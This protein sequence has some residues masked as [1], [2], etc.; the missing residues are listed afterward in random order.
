MRAGPQPPAEPQRPSYQPSV[1][2]PQ[3]P[4]YQ[5]SIFKPQEQIR[6]PKQNSHPPPQ[7]NPNAK[8]SF[9]TKTGMWDFVSPQNGKRFESGIAS[10]RGIVMQAGPQ[11]LA[12]PQP[13]VYQPQRP[14]YQPSVY[15]PGYSSTSVYQPSVYQPQEQIRKPKQNSQQPRQPNPNAKDSFQTKT[16]M[17]DFVSPE[18]GKRFE[19]GIASSRGIV[20]Q[21]GPQPPAEPQPSVYQPQR[22]SYQPSV[23]QP[24]RP[25]YQPS[26]YKPQEQIRKLKQISQKR[27]QS[28]A[29]DSFQTK[30][31]MWDFV[32]PQ[33]GKRFESGIAQSRGIVMRAGPQ[34]PAEPQPSVYQPQR[35]SYQPSVYQPQRPSYQPSVYQPVRPSYQPSVYQPQRPSYQPSVYQPQWPSYQPSVYPLRPQQPGYH[36]KS[37]QVVIQTQPAIWQFFSADGGFSD[38]NVETG[39]PSKHQQHLATEA[40]PPVVTQGTRNYLLRGL[41]R[42]EGFWAVL[43]PVT[44]QNSQQPRQPN[45]NA[46]DSFQTKTGMWDFVS[47]ENGRRFES[48][49]A[50][51]RGIVMQ[52]GPQPPAEPQRPSYQPSVYQPQRPSY[53]PSV[54]QP[55]R[56]SYQPSVFKPQEQ[57]RK[58]KQNSHPP[59]QSNPNAKDSFQTKTGM[60]DFV[61]P[62]NGKRFESGIASSRGIV[63]QAGPQPPA[64]PQPS[65]YQPQRPS[66]QPSVYQPQRPSYQPSVY[67][68]QRPSYQPSVYQHQEQIRKP[69]QNSHPPPQSNPNAKDSFQTKTGMWDFVSP[70]N[71]KRFESGIASSRGIVMQAGPQ[72]LAE[73]QP[74]V[75]QPGYSSTSV[76]QPSVYQPQRP[77]YQ[78]SVYQ[79]QEQ[80]R[81][82]KQNS[83]KQWKK[84]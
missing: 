83:Q 75:D 30:T 76:Y 73:P 70:Q 80:I 81:K 11:P 31:G 21:A 7:S 52:A 54:Y 71:G 64:E 84:I 79:P 60:W 39:S 36:S 42:L 22:P 13:S 77:S 12:E 55:Q 32:S 4:S 49:I 33:N 62:Q 56:P 72:P 78:P 67:Q 3:R 37:Q 9:Q 57:I 47:P 5:P 23:Y 68:P 53:Q 63:M 58:P 16:G 34:P 8:D 25:S 44:V 82:L 10:S 66:Y 59:P 19:S 43:D 35:P 74:S 61:S 2:Q 24:Q 65:V 69:K 17:W 45:P 14:S 50:S 46:K 27:P 6:K 48:G 18:N 51:S 28:N 38:P 26:V 41:N 29:K 15:Q 20:M 1:Y 40:E